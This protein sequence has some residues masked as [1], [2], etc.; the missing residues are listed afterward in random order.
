MRENPREGSGVP[1]IEHL[2]EVRFEYYREE[3][4]Q[5]KQAAEWVEEWNT[6]EKDELPKAIRITLVSRKGEKSEEGTPL[7]LLVSLPSHRYE[8]IKTGPTRRIIPSMP[9]K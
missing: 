6:Q 3:D 7:T 9:V 2:A 8:E 1:L 4:P 5:E